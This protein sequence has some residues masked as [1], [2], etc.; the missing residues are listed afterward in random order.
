MPCYEGD[1]GREASL[2]DFLKSRKCTLS[3]GGHVEI[4]SSSVS[5][6]NQ[7]TDL[8]KYGEVWSEV[9]RK[10]EEIKKREE[11][12][13]E[14]MEEELQ[15]KENKNMEEA[16]K[17]LD[18]VKQL[19][20]TI[21]HLLSRKRARPTL[22]RK[23][24]EAE[25]KKTEDELKKREEEWKGNMKKKEDELQ[26]KDNQISKLQLELAKEKKA[27][28]K[29]Q[30]ELD[31]TNQLNLLSRKRARPTNQ[32]KGEYVEEE[33]VKVKREAKENA[34]QVDDNIESPR[35]SCPGTQENKEHD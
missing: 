32:I 15:E 14:K 21:T 18:A 5:N 10:E 19:L 3:P 22:E 7:E 2:H 28:D 35:R 20:D 33:D 27:H 12:W 16:K 8:E 24:K 31:T 11:E 26:D 9:W 25:K 30:K 17:E 13:T 4:C 23:K 6:N 1:E 34:E 29:A